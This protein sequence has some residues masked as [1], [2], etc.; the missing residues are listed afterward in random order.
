VDG[1]IGNPSGSPAFD[2]IT[3]ALGSG[4][5]QPGDTILVVGMTYNGLPAGYSDAQPPYR[6]YP[7]N[8]NSN[9]ETFPIVVPDGVTI[10]ASGS[11][12][13]YV[14]STAATPVSGLFRFEGSSA[15]PLQQK[16]LKLVL[17]GGED[18][19]EVVAG[20]EDDLDVVLQGVYFGWNQHAVDADADLGSWVDLAATNCTLTDRTI[21]TDPAVLPP[22]LQDPVSGFDLFADQSDPLA[23]PG[24][25]EA[26][27]SNLSLDGSFPTAPGVVF[28]LSAK[29][30]RREH[31]SVP[32]FVQAISE[33]VLDLNGSILDG[34]AANGAAPAGWHEG[35]HIELKRYQGLVLEDFAAG[36]R[37]NLNGSTLKRF[38]DYGIFARGVADTRG[39]IVLNGGSAVLH[40]GYQYGPGGPTSGEPADGIYLNPVEAYLSLTATNAVIYQNARDGISLDVDGSDLSTAMHQPVGCYLGLQQVDLYQNLRDGLHLESSAGVVGGTWLWHGGTRYF[41]RTFPNVMVAQ[42]QGYV[43]RCTINNNGEHGIYI[44]LAA[45]GPSARNFANV[46]LLN[47]FIWNNGKEGY[48]AETNGY[49]TL[50]APAVH[51]T[52]VGN[53]D[54]AAGF[55]N[56]EISGSGTDRR[57]HR[58][59]YG[60]APSYDEIHL[61]T[62][63]WNS[64]FQ[65][66]N[67]GDNDFGFGL[68]ALHALDPGPGGSW[69]DNVVYF[70]GL[71]STE[72]Y[73]EPNQSWWTDQAAPFVGPISYTSQDPS[74]F[75]L[76][77]N[78]TAFSQFNFTPDYLD[79][80]EAPESAHDYFGGSRPDY[81]DRDKGAHQAR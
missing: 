72:D 65:G 40:T 67:S 56:M 51:C 8:P 35:I 42:G 44:N 7:G 3:S 30:Q 55:Y 50:L 43:D 26:T 32:P 77:P 59:E 49:T 54:P 36:V 45:S 4:Q 2:S 38:R 47:S 6:P 74:Q 19:V 48:H 66:K 1:S 29:G 33:V 41:Y 24:H 21:T 80:L 12:P 68:W 78:V 16:L 71:R 75:R 70:R 17:L 10:Q 11:V 39:E 58:L 15:T 28:S 23:E 73:L 69:A 52:F 20:N 46:R 31:L 79:P 18:G 63:L 37:V 14:W 27:V 22:V 76:D 60:P 5:V 81:P 13:V 62:K 53:G 9:P 61:F 57:F 25:I 34:V 64:I